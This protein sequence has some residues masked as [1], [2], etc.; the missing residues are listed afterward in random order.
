[1]KSMATEHLHTL[2]D[3]LRFAVSRFN[4]AQL[5]FGH[6]ND[7]AFDEAVYLLLHSLHLPLDRLEPFLQ[8]RLFPE[9]IANI[10]R[11]IDKRVAQRIPMPYLTQEA[12]LG[13]Y[14][15][16]IDQRAIIPRS[17]IAELLPEALQPWIEHPELVQRALDLCTG[18]G[19][20]GILLAQHYP[21]AHIDAVDISTAALEVAAINV[22]RY[23]L[24]SRI[25]L[26][27]GDLL[28]AL[29][30]QCYDLIVCNPPYVDNQA[31]ASLPEEY[32]H[33][34]ALALAAGSDG[35]AYIREILVQ[36]SQYLNPQGVLLLE[37]G[38]QHRALEAAFP[39]LPFVW[40][41][42]HTGDYFVCLLTA[43]MLKQL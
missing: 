5:C 16:Y 7:N 15:F 11:L 37:V 40:L 4:Q 2:C 41:S 20:L 17:F 1:M 21:D 42:T 8:A 25:T 35:L 22:Q 14:S 10:V 32:R 23:Q 39:T 38:H 9:E 31:M 43:A 27:H 13:E 33:E 19:C 36:A 3:C 29:D 24:E 18:S 12:W 30:K 26:L 28:N 34:P 6:G